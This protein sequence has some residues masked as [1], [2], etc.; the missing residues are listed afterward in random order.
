MAYKCV[1][2]NVFSCHK[3][4]SLTLHR[5][6]SSM[7]AFFVLSTTP[8]CLGHRMC[9]W[10]P[11]AHCQRPESTV[12]TTA[13]P[14]IR[15]RADG[16]SEVRGG[17]TRDECPSHPSAALFYTLYAYLNWYHHRHRLLSYY[18][19]SW[20]PDERALRSC[21][22]M[23]DYYNNNC[24]IVFSVIFFFLSV[25]VQSP[26]LYGYVSAAFSALRIFKWRGMENRKM[27]VKSTPGSFVPVTPP[28]RL[29]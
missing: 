19:R 11:R 15:P 21:R 3:I 7:C 16:S 9:V 5:Y 12:K 17:Q 14:S 4:F 29:Q 28:P 8:Q 27:I 18:F 24:C 1:F 25:S 20:P 10:F 23:R 13:A 2:F 6:K 22:Y 26:R